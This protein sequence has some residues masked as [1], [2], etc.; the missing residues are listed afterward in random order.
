MNDSPSPEEPLLVTVV[1][2]TY[3]HEAFVEQAIRSVMMQE[4]SFRYQLIIGEDR[5]T[6]RTRQIVERLQTEFPKKIRALCRDEN[7]GIIANSADVF[8]RA[9]AQS[10]YVAIVEGDDYWVSPHKLQ[11]QVDH[12]ESLPNCRMS[13]HSAYSDYGAGLVVDKYH[14]IQDIGRVS[15][16]NW[17]SSPFVL[18]TASV[19]FRSPGT[20]L[21]DWYRSVRFS[22]DWALY[23]WLSSLPGSMD[24]LK[25]QEPMSVWR[26]HQGGATSGFRLKMSDP[27]KRLFLLTNLHDHLLLR[28]N[29]QRPIGAAFVGVII[30][31]HWSLLIC[32][33]RGMRLFSAI[34]HYLW[35]VGYGLRYPR[36]L[37]S[38]ARNHK[39]L[40]V[41][42]LRKLVRSG[43]QPSI[44]R[45]SQT[46]SSQE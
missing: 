13:F 24:F 14:P 35:A 1:M 42:V 3:N 34:G 17:L 10:D 6:D 11:R 7:L 39:Q 8:D 41:S 30:T 28:R 44:S 22:G 2:V 21:P 40:L 38:L 33:A 16:E 27:K 25:T 26:S 23:T 32:E 37:K 31:R 4:T 20:R 5:S 29:V 45:S 18:H 19:M 12:M 36:F 43:P 9:I 46:E 15:F